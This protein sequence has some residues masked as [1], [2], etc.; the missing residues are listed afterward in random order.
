MHFKIS[1]NLRQ[2][3][4]NEKQIVDYAGRVT[5]P[6]GVHAMYRSV[7]RLRGIDLS[8]LTRSRM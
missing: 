4:I 6:H 7:G 3:S 1:T 2:Q 8:F 5:N